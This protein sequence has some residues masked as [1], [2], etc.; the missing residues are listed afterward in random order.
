MSKTKEA[1]YKAWFEDQR[2][3]VIM[4]RKRAVVQVEDRDDKVFWEKVF[5]E[6]YPDDEFEFNYYTQTSDGQL[7]TGCTNCLRFLPW[8][9]DNKFVIAIDSDLKYLTNDP[10]INNPFVIHTYTYSIENHLCQAERLNKI[11]DITT[12]LNNDLFDFPNFLKA[13]SR[14]IYPLLILFLYDLK[15]GS[16]V[17]SMARFK[18]AITFVDADLNISNNGESIIKLLH[19]RIVAELATLQ[20]FYPFFD[21]SAEGESYKPLGLNITNSYLYVRGHNLYDLMVAIGANVC[22]ALLINEKSRLE[23]LGET[24]S[25]PA[26]YASKR[27]FKDECNASQLVFD[28]PEMQKCI[29]KIKTIFTES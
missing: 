23:T 12:G 16:Q 21:L 9:A 18:Q 1:Y 6:V 29:N 28:Y 15:Q 24:K 25:I 10:V 3:T 27:H 13:Y 17:Y 4:N 8:I 5:N 20:R 14:E 11:S 19:D 22:D 7:A 26:L 2:A